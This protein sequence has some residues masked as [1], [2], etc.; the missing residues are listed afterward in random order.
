[1][2]AAPPL[3][4]VRDLRT[5]FSTH[6]GV[7]KAVDGVTFHI[8]PGET[9]GIV[10]E[11]GSGKSV[12]ALSIMGLLPKPAGR[13]VGGTILFDGKDLTRAS[14]RTLR[15]LRGDDMALIFQ[16]P[17]TSLNPVFSIGFQLVEPLKKHLK[18]STRAARTR[19]AEL[20]SLVGIPSAAKRLHRSPRALSAGRCGH[21]LR[22]MNRKRSD[23]AALRRL[24]AAHGRAG[25][26]GGHPYLTAWLPRQS[27]RQILV[28]PAGLLASPWVDRGTCGAYLAT[29]RRGVM[30]ANFKIS[31]AALQGCDPAEL[32][33]LT[34][35]VE[36]ILPAIE[37]FWRY[38]GRDDAARRRHGWLARLDVPLPDVGGGIGAVA[39]DLADIVIPNGA[40][41]SEPGWSGFITTGPTTS[42]VAASLAARAGRSPI[43][44]PVSWAIKIDVSRSA[45][46]LGLGSVNRVVRQLSHQ[47]RGRDHGRSL[48]RAARPGC[49][50]GR[51]APGS[52]GPGLRI[53]A[54]ASHHPA[55]HRRARAGP[56]RDP[57]HCV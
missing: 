54:G 28:V 45:W 40:R 8:A 31:T 1:M 43:G 48:N 57:A 18:L 42:A 12:T 41:V 51:P 5:Y 2:D 6:A 3:L 39:A 38:D 37:K 44:R 16:D 23:C 10:G 49:L 53:R 35:T 21:S 27:G 34:A 17:M 47:P 46:A 22:R 55:G 50:P 24:W 9:V 56:C 36:R 33:Q 7:V 19:A 14:D 13:I 29:K 25:F 15:E 30:D 52:A 11:S 32:G 4:D 26:A 20:L